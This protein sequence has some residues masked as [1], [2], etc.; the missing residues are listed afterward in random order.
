MADAL[1]FDSKT[2][3]YMQIDRDIRKRILAGEL[4]AGDQLMS[5][6]QY[7]TT[8]RINPATANKAFNQLAAD[9]IIYK[10]R[11]IGMFVTDDAAAILRGEGRESYESDRLAPVIREGLALG[12]TSQQIRQL[13]NDILEEQ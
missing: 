9:G 5:T 6:T 1:D 2:P 8:Y 7:A 11:G 13:V 4:A 3:I 12:Y 10:Q